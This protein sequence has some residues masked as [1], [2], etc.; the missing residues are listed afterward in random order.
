M[1][2]LATWWIFWKTWRSLTRATS[3]WWIQFSRTITQKTGQSRM[4]KHAQMLPTF[5]NHGAEKRTWWSMSFLA[6]FHVFR[7]TRRSRCGRWESAPVPPFFNVETLWKLC[8][9]EVVFQHLQ[10]ATQG[11]AQATWRGTVWH[12][13]LA[14]WFWEVD[15]LFLPSHILGQTKR[16]SK[17]SR[18]WT[19]RASTNYVCCIHIYM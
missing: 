19:G 2:R 4:T 1:L 9:F 15:F 5:T 14:K 10:R 18:R 8:R 6:R 7:W 16:I 3:F 12:I 13:A 17:L 11:K